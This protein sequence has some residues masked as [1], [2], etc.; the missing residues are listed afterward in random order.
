MKYKPS[1]ICYCGRRIYLLNKSKYKDDL[2]VVHSRCGK[3][4]KHYLILKT[5]WDRY[6]GLDAGCK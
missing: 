2:R 5:D 1:M 4:K 3:C 6:S